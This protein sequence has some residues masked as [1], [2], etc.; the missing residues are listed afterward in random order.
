MPKKRRRFTPEFKARVALEAMKERESI[1]ELAC[2]FGV[3]PTQISAWKKELK[4]KTDA[5]FAGKHELLNENAVDEAKS[6]LH[7]QIGRL[8][9]EVDFLRKKLGP[10]L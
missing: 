1:A 3:H 8:Q 7:E 4:E 9:V 2:R 6:L 10:F 5:L